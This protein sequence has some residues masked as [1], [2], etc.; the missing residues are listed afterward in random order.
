MSIRITRVDAAIAAVV[1]ALVAT[2]A[3]AEVRRSGEFSSERWNISFATP[4]DWQVTDETTYP[5]ILLIMVTR[6]PRGRMMVSAQKI[7]DGMDSAAFAQST[8]ELLQEL[9]FETSAPQLHPTT[10]AYWIDVT[11]PEA[12]LRQA[13]VTAGD[14]GYALTLSADSAEARADHVRAFDSV[15]RSINLDR[16]T[17]KD[18]SE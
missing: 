2:A 10:G 3:R 9:G 6:S 15:L 8:V 11:T 17:P 18:D 13:F 4:R 7:D 14:T 1:F 5:S 16:T 12:V